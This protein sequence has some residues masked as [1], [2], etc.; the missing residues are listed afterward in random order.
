ML[1]KAKSNSME[2]VISKA[3]IDSNMS[4]DE[5]FLINN[6]LK[7]YNYMKEEIKKLQM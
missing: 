3:L 6:L 7:E 4:H 1:G 2:V 5:F